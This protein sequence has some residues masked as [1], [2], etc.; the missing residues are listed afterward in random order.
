MADFQATMKWREKHEGFKG[1]RIVVVPRPV[2]TTALREPLLRNLMPTDAGYYPKAK[3]HT[4]AREH[5]TPE[6]IFIYCAEGEGWCELDGRRHEIAANQLLVVPPSMPHVYGAAKSA[7]W[8]IHWFHAVGT[9]VPLYIERLGV[10]K[11]KPV[12]SLSGNVYLFSL[13]EEVV[14][15]L[16]HGFTLPHLIY[17]GHALTH[18]MGLLLRHK[19]EYGFG[20][21]SVREQIAKSVEFMKGHLNE[22]LNV[23]T[24]AA[25]V[26]LSRSHYTTLFRRVTGYAPLSY[27]N[28]LRMQQAVQLLNGTDLPIKQ[29]SERLGF[30]EQF[31]FSRAFSRMHNHSPSEHR[32]RYATKALG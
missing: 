4:C 17:A 20:A 31:Y 26:N 8:S 29:I 30:S 28:H 23:A 25:L 22:P 1:Q 2:L 21:P 11:G 19:E 9:N 13:F 15:A 10:A 32:R 18:L 27:L 5:G 24:L 6:T 14:E 12:V 7:P 16:E 3:G